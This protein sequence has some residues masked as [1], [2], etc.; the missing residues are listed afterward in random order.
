M[1]RKIIAFILAATCL[2]S[3]TSFGVFAYM[4]PA[5]MAEALNKKAEEEV[6]DKNVGMA[7][8]WDF[9]DLETVTKEYALDAYSEA[10]TVAASGRYILT[11]EG[12]DAVAAR[13]VEGLTNVRLIE[14]LDKAQA[15]TV[16][17]FESVALAGAFKDALSAKY[18]Q[19]EGAPYVRQ[20]GYTVLEGTKELAYLIGVTVVEDVVPVTSAPTNIYK[21]YS[22]G[23][24]CG[25]EGCEEC[26]EGT[27]EKYEIY[28]DAYTAVNPGAVGVMSFKTPDSAIRIVD[29]EFVLGKNY[30]DYHTTAQDL[31]SGMSTYEGY[32]S[33]DAYMDVY[34]SK[35][36]YN[37]LHDAY[38]GESFVFSVRLKAPYEYTRADLSGISSTKIN[39]FT[40]RSHFAKNAVNEKLSFDNPI[41]KYDIA[42]QEIIICSGGTEVSTGIYLTEYEY[43]TIAV[44]VKPKTNTFDFYA[45]GVLVAEGAKFLTDANIAKIYASETGEKTANTADYT[46]TLF[47][48]FQTGRKLLKGDILCADDLVLY[49]SDEYLEK[50]ESEN[51]VTALSVDVGDKFYM[52]FFLN[53]PTTY[54]NDFKSKI[55]LSIGEERKEIMLAA[56]ERVLDGEYA[57]FMKYTLPLSID[58]LGESV[59]ISVEPYDA[60]DKRTPYMYGGDG[61]DNGFRGITSYSTVPTD[62]FKYL[63]EESN[64]FDLKTRNVARA[65]LNYS[66]YLEVYEESVKSGTDANPD[67]LA[68]EGCE[69]TGEEL[70]AVTR[71]SFIGAIRSDE[72]KKYSVEGTIDGFSVKQSSLM[73]GEGLDVLVKFTYTGGGKLTLNGKSVSG[74]EK[75]IYVSDIDLAPE[76]YTLVFEDGKGIVRI[77]ISTYMLA[78]NILDAP[79]TKDYTKNLL[80]SVYLFKSALDEYRA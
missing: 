79:A 51:T 67:G 76:V 73:L 65:V 24:K 70:A 45:D 27:C 52:N 61:G 12:A 49:Y 20:C 62:Y 47:R 18:E 46:M 44:H 41:I 10:E 34:P 63:F 37:Q 64:G 33:S 72:Y 19:E 39:I 75:R 66:A 77:Q 13:E 21:Q 14:S 48:V 53:F 7:F 15:V 78:V 22:G 43:C 69:Y 42:T 80:R 17:K 29:G 6:G 4:T 60:E 68:N 50:S 1:K 35:L 40:P 55:V 56:G 31:P 74:T 58:E 32:M 26:A 2:F 25:E 8:G 57:G 36:T 71:E 23:T 5:E 59:S 9:D 16:Y 11:D 3:V 28:D 30:K 54:L 38:G